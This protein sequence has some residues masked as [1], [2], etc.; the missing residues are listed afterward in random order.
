MKRLALA[1]PAL[2]LLAPAS[3]SAQQY[4]YPGS[5]AN[6]LNRPQLSPYL[7]LLRGGNVASNYFLGTI[8]EQQR[9]ANDAIFRAQIQSLE[10]RPLIPAVTATDDLFGALPGSGHET[11]FLNYGGYYAQ[12]ARFAQPINRSAPPPQRAPR[13]GGRGG[14]E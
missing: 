10:T 4:G 9:R 11:A 5:Y 13:P 7:N 3:A 1:L 8:P 6:T 14:F 2:L 12:G